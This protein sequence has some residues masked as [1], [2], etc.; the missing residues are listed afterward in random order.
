MWTYLLLQLQ[1]LERGRIYTDIN[2]TSN[3]LMTQQ[4][5]L[6]L[7]QTICSEVMAELNNAYSPFV[8]CISSLY[9][10]QTYL[11]LNTD[12][13]M[14]RCFSINGKNSDRNLSYFVLVLVHLGNAEKVFQQ[15][16]KQ[17]WSKSIKTFISKVKQNNSS[18]S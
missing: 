12:R 14:H 2:L 8:F 13:S 16:F 7:D 15:K 10:L 17:T 11:I 6:H 18:K 4:V 5:R 9:F 1:F 3:I